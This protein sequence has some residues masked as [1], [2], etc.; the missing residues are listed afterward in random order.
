MG[1][2]RSA[3]FAPGK[4]KE[5]TLWV[6]C[7]A[8][9]SFPGTSTIFQGGDS[10]QVG[11][12]GVLATGQALRAREASSLES[13]GHAGRVFSSRLPVS[14]L[15]RVAF[16]R[17]LVA[18]LAPTI[19]PL[20]GECR[21][22]APTIRDSEERY[23]IGPTAGSGSRAR[24]CRCRATTPAGSGRLAAGRRLSNGPNLFR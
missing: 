22:W 12:P 3:P 6:R 13:C 18:G 1:L 10:A 15:G 21:R 5:P 24:W 17:M 14:G 4:S 19:R 7:W 20:G 16:F 8:Q 2:S 23:H 11:K 9:R